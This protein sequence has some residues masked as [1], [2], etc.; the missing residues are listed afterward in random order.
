MRESEWEAGIR[1]TICRRPVS[2][3][4]VMTCHEL[5]HVSWTQGLDSSGLLAAAT[6][7]NHYYDPPRAAIFVNYI[8]FYEGSWQLVSALD[9][10]MLL[11]CCLRSSHA[12]LGHIRPNIYLR[13]SLVIS[14]ELNW[15]GVLQIMS[16][17]R[18]CQVS[19]RR[20]ERHRKL[21]VLFS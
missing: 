5:C 18:Q 14:E 12:T 2:W 11:K 1:N 20:W 15:A 4:I 3:E 6:Q 19:G 8:Y 10:V 17:F 7:C 13:Q 16:V 21:L 9:C